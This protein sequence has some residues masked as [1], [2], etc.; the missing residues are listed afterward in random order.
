MIR[1]A[2]ADP[3]VRIGSLVLNP[4]GPG[5]SGVDFTAAVYDRLPA[6][7]R[8]RFDVVS[9]D[10]RGVARSGGIE[11]WD[12]AEYDA[13]FASTQV[14][15]PDRDRFGETVSRAR[16]LVHACVRNAGRLLPYIGTGYVARDLDLLRAALGDRKL[17]YLGLSYGTFLGTSTPTCSRTGCG[18]W[19]STVCSTRARMP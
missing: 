1:R 17:T 18:R 8:S 10:P 14:D 9:F 2:A 13:A 19:S 15:G 6:E 4:G 16:R 5:G 11:C 12:R 7:L 3:A